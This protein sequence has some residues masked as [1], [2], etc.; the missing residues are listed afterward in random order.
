MRGPPATEKSISHDQF[1]E[2]YVRHER[3]IYSYISSLVVNRNDIEDIFQ[4][5]CMVLW[6]KWNQ[7]DPV[8]DFAGWGCGIARNEVRNYLR[9]RRGVLRQF[10]DEAI[11]GISSEHLEMGRQLDVRHQA[12]VDCLAKLPPRQ[13]ELV[14][15][16][17][18]D[19]NSIRSVAQ[20]L[21][22]TPTALYMKLHRIRRALLDCISLAL[23]GEA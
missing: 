10:S 5:T 18:S 6:K 7:Y 1:A 21:R 22:L 9:T 2:L 16:C 23:R 11:E 19:D 4:Q 3:R 13:R 12:L 8:Y 14:E 15:K 20:S 17:Y